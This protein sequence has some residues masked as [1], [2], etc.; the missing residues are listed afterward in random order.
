VTEELETICRL[1][2]GKFLVII[3]DAR[4]FGTDPDYPSVVE[5]ENLMRTLRPDFSMRIE[6]D[7]LVLGEPS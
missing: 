3:D 2:P 7:A 6:H 4:L 1:C 5:I